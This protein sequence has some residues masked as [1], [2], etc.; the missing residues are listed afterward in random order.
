MTRPI[1]RRDKE[2]PLLHSNLALHPAMDGDVFLAGD[3][4]V[5]M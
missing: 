4:T 2:G 5:D 1:G 3:L